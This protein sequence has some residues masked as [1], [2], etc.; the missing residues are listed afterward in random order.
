[1]TDKLT[2]QITKTTDGKSEYLQVMSG[3]MMTINIVL[4]ADKIEVRDDRD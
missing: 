4:I 2:V 3:D 1:M